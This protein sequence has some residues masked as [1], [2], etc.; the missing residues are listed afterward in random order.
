MCVCVPDMHTVELQ[1]VS[2]NISENGGTAPP[3]MNTAW[4]HA[5]SEH[6]LKQK[7]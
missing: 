2:F 4:T 5:Q 7:N 6:S 3:K 1:T